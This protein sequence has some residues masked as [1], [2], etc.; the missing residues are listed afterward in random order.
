M[1]EPQEAMIKYLLGQAGVT[2]LTGTRIASKHHYGEGWTL[3]ASGLAV[4]MDGGAPD[5]YAPE[6]RVRLELRAYANSPANAMTLYLALVTVSRNTQRATV[7]TLAG[8]ALVQ[9]FLPASGAS[10]LYEPTIE[11]NYVMVI[12]DAVVGE[13]NIS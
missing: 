4:R 1:I 3:G 6:Q 13:G 5:I 8:T 9:S 2:A 10:Q 7:S 11:M 12:F